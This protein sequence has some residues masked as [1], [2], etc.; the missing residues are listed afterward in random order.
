MSKY[1]VAV[2]KAVKY[3]LTIKK[4]PTANPKKAKKTA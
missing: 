2:K 1:K 4:P 3:K